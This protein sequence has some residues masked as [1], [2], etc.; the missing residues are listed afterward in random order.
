MKKYRKTA[1]WFGYAQ[2]DDKKNLFQRQGRYGHRDIDSDIF[3]PLGMTETEE[4]A[5]QNRIRK[6]VLICTAAIIFTFVISYLV[7]MTCQDVYFVFP[8]MQPFLS[9]LDGLLR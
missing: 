6:I 1:A 9:P 7:Y 2:I 3:V 5:Y 4:Y 8:F